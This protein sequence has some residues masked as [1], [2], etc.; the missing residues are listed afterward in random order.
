MIK[1]KGDNKTARQQREDRGRETKLYTNLYQST[2]RKAE[3]RS[4]EEAEMVTRTTKALEI[5]RQSIIGF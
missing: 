2:T 3:I 4:S 1:I 5:H